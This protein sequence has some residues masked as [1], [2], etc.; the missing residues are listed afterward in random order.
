MHL[1]RRELLEPQVRRV[2]AEGDSATYEVQVR[3]RNAGE[4]PTALRQAQLVKI[5][6]QDEARLEFDGALL[7]GESPR[8]RMVEP[9]GPAI[10]SG[11]TEPGETKTAAYRV[12]VR[13]DGPVTAT[14]RLL[15][16]R[17]GVVERE[18]SIGG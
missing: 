17:G 18:I 10:D 7:R 12:T 15:S 4:L 6:R 8:V 16:T 2:S 13:G 11:W 3:W 9:R 14:V 5:V 1:P